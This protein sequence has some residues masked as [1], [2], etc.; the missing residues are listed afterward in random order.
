VLHAFGAE[1]ASHSPT[2]IRYKSK[3]KAKSAYPY[4]PPPKRIVGDS[5]YSGLTIQAASAIPLPPRA[6]VQSRFRRETC[7]ND[8]R[9]RRAMS[10]VFVAF[11]SAHRGEPELRPALQRGGPFAPNG[12]NLFRK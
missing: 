5:A 3:I 2:R 4:I 11:A 8:D 7:D 6:A 10:G 12:F 1:S 9:F